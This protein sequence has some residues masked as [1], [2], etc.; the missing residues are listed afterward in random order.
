MR[1]RRALKLLIGLAT[2][3]ACLPAFAEAKAYELV[4]YLGKTAATQ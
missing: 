1:L 3:A 2:V 4:K